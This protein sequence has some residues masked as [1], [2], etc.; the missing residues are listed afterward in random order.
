M[1]NILTSRENAVIKNV[2]KLYS[3][4]KSRKEQSCF[5][6]EG[7]RISLDAIQSGVGIK[8]FFYTE[9]AKEKWNDSIDILINKASK[10][11]IINENIASILS[12]TKTP[13]GI[14]CTCTMLD[15]QTN[16]NKIKGQSLIIG[17]EN[18][19]DP[20]NMGS[21]IRTAE[22]LGIGSI[23]LSDDCCDLYSPK[24]LRGSMGG[25]F[26]IPFLKVQSFKE[27]VCELNYMGVKT[28]AAVPKMDGEPITDISFS[29]C[30]SMVAIGNE[31]KGLTESTINSCSGKL[32]IPMSSNA[33]S[34]N[35]SVACAIIMWE[36]TRD[37]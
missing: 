31:G 26:R 9:K 24:V 36:M 18:I 17:L 12:D 19:Q 3:S 37:R 33:E 34:L 32:T 20:S 29:Q 35:A 30:R 22:A 1:E 2:L 23:I 8:E 5:I 16:L 13:Q 14:F 25:V 21:I 6:I 15:K 7:L 28:Y 4:S 11:Y 27:A 10:S